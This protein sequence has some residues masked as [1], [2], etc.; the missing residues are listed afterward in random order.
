MGGNYCVYAHISP[1]QKIYVGL[2]SLKPE[3]RWNGGK[4]YLS[5][6][7]DGT[8]KQPHFARAI[9]TYGWEN[10]RHIVLATGLTKEQ[11]EQLECDLISEYNSNNS[12]YGYNIES[13][14]NS[15]GKTSEETKMKISKLMSG[16]NNPFYGKHHTEESKRKIS[17]N[18]KGLTCGENHHLHGKHRSDDVKRA[19]GEKAK[20]RLKNKENH[21]MYGR[22]G[23]DNP[24]SMS[25]LQIDKYTDDVIKMWD[26]IADASRALGINKG[27]ISACCNGRT[28]TSGGFKW[29]F[30]T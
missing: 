9:L 29:Q 14:G 3:Y 7:P 26:S 28:N 2:T 27:A 30:A 24:K 21:P 19:I 5:R 17:E 22:R 16:S 25:V 10:F 12:G 6:N 1:S 15:K 23:K 8:Y 18:R 13:G 4:G 20:E 11:A